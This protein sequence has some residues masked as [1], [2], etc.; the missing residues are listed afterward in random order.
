MRNVLQSFLKRGTR[1]AQETPVKLYL[2][3]HGAKAP[4]SRRKFSPN[5]TKAGDFYEQLVE[6][7]GRPKEEIEEALRYEL[8]KAA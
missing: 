8:L 2:F 1:D 5:G 7:Y 3:V 6:D 4:A